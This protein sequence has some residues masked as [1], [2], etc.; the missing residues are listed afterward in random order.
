LSCT[1]KAQTLCGK[2]NGTCGDGTK[3]GTE[4]CDLGAK[5]ADVLSACTT[6]CQNSGLIAYFNASDLR[7]N[8]FAPTNGSKV[9]QW[10]DL[11]GTKHAVQAT[12]ARQPTYN[13]SAINGKPAVQFDGVDDVLAVPLDISQTS[14]N[15]LTIVA[16]LQNGVGNPNTYASV[17]G[18]DNGGF[19]RF[20]ISG[21]IGGLA[22]GICDGGSTIAVPGITAEATPLIV[23]ATMRNGAGANTS[24]VHLNG[25]LAA[26]YAENHSSSGTSMMSIGN[27]EGPPGTAAFTFDGFISVIAVY[28]HA[29]TAVERDGVQA[30]LATVYF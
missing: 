8:G 23:I 25:M 11:A 14:Y 19:D 5:N 17:W 6:Q 26:T 22:K 13:G 2:C 24:S 21:G 4:A 18:N 16:V 9:V 30:K 3:K 29:L 10:F 1:N 12:V 15:D 20:L 7:G 28:D 27:L